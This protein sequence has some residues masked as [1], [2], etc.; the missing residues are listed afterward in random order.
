ML[1]SIK[2]KVA[3]KKQKDGEEHMKEPEREAQ[4]S[5]ASTAAVGSVLGAGAEVLANADDPHQGAPAV[6]VGGLPRADLNRASVATGRIDPD[7]GGVADAY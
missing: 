5:S 7:R 6:A 3:E 4:R 1:M 2:K